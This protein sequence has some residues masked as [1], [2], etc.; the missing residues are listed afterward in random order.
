[1][2]IAVPPFY[3]AKSLAMAVLIVLFGASA[4]V[5]SSSASASAAASSTGS[6][7]GTVYGQGVPN[8]PLAG[9]SVSLELPGGSYVQF[10]TTAV[11]G[12]YL[13]SGLPAAGYVLDF[14]PA[15]GQNFGSVWWNG[16]AGI[17]TATVVAVEGGASVA[18]ISPTLP[19]AGT[20]SGT[21]NTPN[22]PGSNSTVSIFNSSGNY[23]SASSADSTGAYSVIG[24]APGS[25]TADFAA[26]P[27]S[28]LVDQWWNGKSSQASADYFTV[29]GGQV[30]SGIDGSLSSGASVSGIIAGA[31]TPN[32]RLADAEVIAIDSTG[33]YAGFTQSVADGSYS[34]TG[35]TAGSYT[36][37]FSAPI[38][39]D[40]GGQWWQDQ[41]S[42]AAADYFTVST[43]QA[44][45]GFDAV[46]PVA[47]GISGTVLG[48]GSPNLPLGGVTVGA[49]TPGSLG[50][51]GYA[52][53]YPDGTYT[54]PGLAPGSYTVNFLAQ[55]P[56]TNATQ[57]WQG[58]ATQSTAT[59]VTVTAGAMT[60][61]ISAVLGAGATV[62][63]TIS[64]KSAS[65]SVFPAQNANANLYSE[66]GTFI[67]DT[68][69]DN[70]GDFS[71]SNLA[72]GS[73]LLQF[74]PR[75][76]TTDFIPQWWKNKS[77]AATA[78][79]ITVRAGEVRS[80]ID[81]IL[82]GSTLKATTP[83]IS[84]I[85]KVGRTLT[86]K[87]GKWGPGTVVFSYQW[88]RNGTAV[89]GAISSTY[90]STTADAGS[91]ITVTVTG[92]EPNHTTQSLTS[93]RTVTIS[94]GGLSTVAPTINGIPTHGQILTA[95]PGS[96][97]P[98][99]VAMT[100]KWF[101]GS[102]PITRVTS[103]TY[104]LTSA[105]IGKSITVRVTGAENGFTPVTVA[106]TPTPV[107]N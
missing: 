5:G 1:M 74:T 51:V 8:A 47:G 92:S 30:T 64:G 42:Q 103:S 52:T 22:G 55:Y 97:G 71:I 23:V 63:G 53:T 31:G 59:P 75:G 34:L 13:F 17:S 86:A 61:G 40:F 72:P 76:D 12:S 9:A 25:Y 94:G 80:N 84:G 2:T 81:P 50:A 44:L 3:R 87:S 106:S 33:S 101:R 14:S 56:E 26:P 35:L 48:A 105:D 37:Q 32:V 67:S 24:V 28:G 78:T 36:V 70:R 27:G 19:V 46:L 41:P 88:A 107:V 89:Q 98:G 10:T 69:A 58:G 65:G 85:P 7:S 11:D 77:T 21:V 95:A 38:G 82:A 16:Q 73:Y 57:W 102:S 68:Y 100:Y 79:P 91:T 29:T 96:W 83:K 4:L 45:T 43:G 99:T 20:V 18:N 62:S 90:V 104:T 93:A 60:T 54:L 66:D 49:F 39:S 15:Y 6:I